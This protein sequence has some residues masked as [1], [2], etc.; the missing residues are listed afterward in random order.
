MYKVLCDFEVE[1]F[2]LFKSF[3]IIFLL[4]SSLIIILILLY[5]FKSLFEELTS[6]YIFNYFNFTKNLSNHNLNDFKSF[7]HLENIFSNRFKEKTKVFFNNYYIDLNF[8]NSR[9]FLTPFKM[10]YFTFSLCDIFLNIID[11]TIER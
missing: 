11:I 2:L 10:S 5:Y 1:S 4:T 8:Y 6:Y 7:S 9:F 3:S